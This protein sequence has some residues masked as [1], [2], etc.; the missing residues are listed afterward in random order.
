M[1]CQVTLIKG[2]SP[3]SC[4]PCSRCDVSRM[5]LT[6]FVGGDV[7]HGRGSVLFESLTVPH[8]SRRVEGAE[9]ANHPPE[10]MSDMSTSFVSFGDKGKRRL[11]QQTENAW[12]GHS[13]SGAGR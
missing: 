1:V 7:Y 9:C 4:L 10:T 5:L 2:D 11:P 3:L 6:P 12:T 8:I 13:Q